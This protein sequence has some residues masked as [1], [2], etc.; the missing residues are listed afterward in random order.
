MQ[1]NLTARG[2]LPAWDECLMRALNQVSAP[3]HEDSG[4]VIGIED[5]GG[6]VYRLVRTN[7]LHETVRVFESAREL[8]FGIA[9]GRMTHGDLTHRVLRRARSMHS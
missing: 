9:G 2:H 4:M 7:G 6:A 3:N 5:D 1:S 8:G